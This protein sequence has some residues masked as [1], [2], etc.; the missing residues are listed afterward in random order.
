M[1]SSVVSSSSFFGLSRF[2]S[3]VVVVVVVD[4]VG[5]GTSNPPSEKPATTQLSVL[6]RDSAVD[7]VVEFVL[8]GG[9]K[10]WLF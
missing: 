7:P 1:G 10:G 3:E 9:F 8:S 2:E 6:V 4:A 5:S